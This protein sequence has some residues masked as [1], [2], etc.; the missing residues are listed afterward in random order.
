MNHLIR[1]A[2]LLALGAYSLFCFRLFLGAYRFLAIF[3]LGLLLV[4]GL[5]LI[6]A[7]LIWAHN[8]YIYN[9]LAKGANLW[10]AGAVIAVLMFAAGILWAIYRV[11]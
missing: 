9:R 11:R 10:L 7:N 3:G 2:I 1:I 4:V 5:V 6:F 8:G